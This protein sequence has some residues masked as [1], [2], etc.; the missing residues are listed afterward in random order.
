MGTKEKTRETVGGVLMV[1]SFLTSGYVSDTDPSISKD[2][3]ELHVNDTIL[4][5]LMHPSAPQ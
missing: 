2:A 5:F 4:D 1:A 3:L